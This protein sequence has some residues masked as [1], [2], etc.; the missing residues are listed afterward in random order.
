[1]FRQ[2]F[3]FPLFVFAGG[4]EFVFALVSREFEFL[5]PPGTQSLF[6]GMHV[7]PH[8]FSVLGSHCIFLSPQ[9]TAKRADASASNPSISVINVFFI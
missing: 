5:F 8:G 3:R 9:E 2:E 6:T 1:M 4:R 7:S